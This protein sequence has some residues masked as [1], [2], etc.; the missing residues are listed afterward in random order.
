MDADFQSMA[1]SGIC[2]QFCR[3]YAE[4]RALHLR[5]QQHYQPASHSRSRGIHN[6]VGM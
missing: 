4:M 1:I 6:N 2:Q 5:S 3:R